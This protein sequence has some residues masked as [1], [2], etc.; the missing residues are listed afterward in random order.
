MASVLAVGGIGLLRA[1]WHRKADN[2]LR[3]I[4]GWGLVFA[5]IMGWGLTSGP[6][7]GPALGIL[8]A[9]LIVL[10]FLARAF[11]V[12]DI[13]PKKD[14]ADRV[15][16]R[17][18][19]NAFQIINRV[20][21]GILIGPFAGLAALSFSTACFS[22]LKKLHVEHTLNLTITS[23]L[24]PILWGILAVIAGYST[25]QITKTATIFGVAL[26]P[27]AYILLSS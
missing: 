22:L 21:A 15:L 6:D 18:P 3:L 9:V 25:K 23:F 24:F 11:F 19:L 13:R 10:G 4:A 7:K 16:E 17:E 20:W 8:V 12:A 1:A 14:K 2:A 26:V 5:S 27:L